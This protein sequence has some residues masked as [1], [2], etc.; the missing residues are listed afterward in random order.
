[1]PVRIFTTLTVA[2]ALN[3]QNQPGGNRDV[4]QGANFFSVEKEVALGGQLAAEFRRQHPRL[5]SAT[6][7]D[8][9]QQLGGRL[10]APQQSPFTFH[11]EV[12]TDSGTTYPEPAAFPGGYVFVPAGL[13]LAANDEAELAGTMAHSVAHILA[14]HGTRQA[15]K[16]GVAQ[17]GTIPLFFMAGWAGY[18][19]GGWGGSGAQGSNSVVPTGFLQSQRTFESEADRLAVTIAADAGYDPEGLARYIGRVQQDPGR[20]QRDPPST[21][22]PRAFPL[23][24]PSR[25]ER[26]Q[27]IEQA[28]QALPV[29]SYSV[30]GDFA[31][32][33]E[34]IRRTLPPPA[35]PTLTKRPTLKR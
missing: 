2:L 30:S 10:V 7:G 34:E 31:R 16:L 22:P 6:V 14:R 19:M 28:I 18:G 27:A 23:P 8:Y 21:A 32:I 5:E 25:D 13:I 29:R 17:S 15:I 33:Q 12:N 24:F 4:G 3:A 9:I 1:M 26:V 11:F 35:P 20:V